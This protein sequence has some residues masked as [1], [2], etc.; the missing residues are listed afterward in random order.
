MPMDLYHSAN[1]VR[2]V[3]PDTITADKAADNYVDMQGY[4]EGA[5]IIIAVGATGDTIDAD[6]YI[7]HKVT[8]CET[9]GGSYTAVPR[10]NIMSAIAA[11]TAGEIS[12]VNAATHTVDSV[13]HAHVRPTMRYIKVSADVTGT[14]TNGTPQSITVVR[15]GKKYQPATA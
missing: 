6:N 4:Q 5:L 8:E 2:V 1:V 10:T 12:L 11:G 9:S 14:H 13:I 3:D 15:L 7:V